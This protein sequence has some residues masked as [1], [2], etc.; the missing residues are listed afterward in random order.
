M[1]CDMGAAGGWAAGLAQ[2][3]VLA[4]QQLPPSVA[5]PRRPKRFALIPLISNPPPMQLVELVWEAPQVVLSW[6]I[7]LSHLSVLRLTRIP[8]STV[9]AVKNVVSGMSGLASLTLGALGVGGRDAPPA[10]LGAL[11]SEGA[12]TVSDPASL[13]VGAAPLSPAPR[14]PRLDRAPTTPDSRLASPLAS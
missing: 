9:G 14:S 1:A 8:F 6:V 3:Q 7:V 10:V 2:Q 4:T 13:F 11:P 12:R 5:L